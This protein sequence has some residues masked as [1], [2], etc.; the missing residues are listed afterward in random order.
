MVSKQCMFRQ[1]QNRFLLVH[2]QLTPR[3]S[4][5]QTLNI[6]GTDCI[7]IYKFNYHA[8]IIAPFSI[9]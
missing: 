8:I 2:C 4:R 5:I 7:G 3:L 9:E 1:N 6:I